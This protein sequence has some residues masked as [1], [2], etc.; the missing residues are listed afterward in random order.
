M[1][2]ICSFVEPSSSIVVTSVPLTSRRL[3]DY[4]DGVDLLFCRAQ[5]FYC[6]DLCPMQA[7]QQKA[8]GGQAH[9][10]HSATSPSEDKH[11]LLS[12]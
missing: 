2:W 10:F 7:D 5:P 6:G 12:S 9:P 3:E 8:A 1:G 11:F 4:L